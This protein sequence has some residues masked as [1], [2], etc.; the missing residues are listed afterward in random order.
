MREWADKRDP[1]R[2]MNR[3]YV[4]ESTLS[5]TGMNADHRFRVKPSEMPRIALALAAKLAAE[6]PGSPRRRAEPEGRSTRSAR[7]GLN[8]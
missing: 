3:L 1:S 7:A 5:V 2:E 6:A 4:V 8:R